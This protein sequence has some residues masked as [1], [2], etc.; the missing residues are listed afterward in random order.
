M[1][2]QER[3]TNWL[4]ALQQQ[5]YALVS[6]M[7]TSKVLNDNW[8]DNMNAAFNDALKIRDNINNMLYNLQNEDGSEE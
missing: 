1:T 3:T 8:D 6:K 5:V 2:H 7:T 4:N